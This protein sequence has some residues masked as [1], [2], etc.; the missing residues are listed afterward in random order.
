MNLFGKKKREDSRKKATLSAKA[1][2]IPDA[3]G[4]QPSTSKGKILVVDDDKVV[5][6][7]LTLKLQ[8]NG[9]QVIS[10]GDGATAVSLV[11]NEKPDLV[12][13]DINFPPDIG[14]SW[15]GFNILEWFRS[16]PEAQLVPVILITGE[17]SPKHKGRAASVGAAAFFQKPIKT[18]ELLA[19]IRKILA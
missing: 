19:T 10:A 8:S 13:L 1:E 18:E 15:D 17:D 16:L 9:Y 14:M 12:I 4:G 7:A 2:P 3:N 6:M 5:V 11:R